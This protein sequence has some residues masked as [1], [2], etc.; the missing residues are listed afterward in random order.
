MN[1]LRAV[2]PL[3]QLETALMRIVWDHPS[4][5]AREVCD[6]LTG[7]RERAYTTVMTTLDRL[8]RKGVLDREKDGQAW[9]YAAR[10]GRSEFE[11]ALAD[12]LAVK[13]LADHGDTALSA[14]VDAVEQ[15]DQAL[16][17]K[18][19]QLVA[20]RQSAKR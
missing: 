15:V 18:L 10:L 13:I 1:K 17:D 20:K 16:F 12:Q 3:G 19:A 5:T 2:Q 4:V 11:R 8:H 14:F 9:R 6:R 7:Q